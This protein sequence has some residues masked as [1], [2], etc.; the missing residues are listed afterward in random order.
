[1]EDNDQAVDEV[2][3]VRADVG[4]GISIW[5]KI[6]VYEGRIPRWLL[7]VAR[8]SYGNIFA[9]SLRRGDYGTV[10]IWDHEEEGDDD[11]P[12]IE[13]NITLVADGWAEF[14]AGLSPR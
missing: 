4:E 7:P 5:D 11:F 6:E 2:F 13:N 3:S 9:L 12:P 8:D 14:I 1:M 10:W